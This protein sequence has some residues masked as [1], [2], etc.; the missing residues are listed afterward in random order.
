MA[1]DVKQL[2]DLSKESIKARGYLDRILDYIDLVQKQAGDIGADFGPAGDQVR[3][4]SDKIGKNIEDIKEQVETELNKIEVDPDATKDAAEKLM[5]YHGT[6]HQVISWADTQKSNYPPESYWW[7]YW[8]S[9][10][11]N[12]MLIEGAKEELM[13]K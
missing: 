10:L 8:T 7:R 6:I 13:K 3:E 12:V 5:L 2:T 4:L 11:E 1:L 9:V